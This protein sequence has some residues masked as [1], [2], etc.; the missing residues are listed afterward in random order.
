[1]STDVMDRRT[2]FGT[3]VGALVAAV[4][5][6][7]QRPDWKTH[8]LEY[9]GAP[10]VFDAACMSNRVYFLCPTRGPLI[11]GFGFPAIRCASR[12]A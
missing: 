9:R 5:P 7:R 3:T 4:L 10:V 11:F 8:V 2:F 6:W 1:M 12:I